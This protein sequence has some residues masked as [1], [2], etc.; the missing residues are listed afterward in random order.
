M[1]STE[2][3]KADI[4]ENFF[5]EDKTAARKWAAVCYG[6]EESRTPVRRLK[7]TAF[8]ERSGGFDIPFSVRPVAG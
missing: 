4:R 1:K 6:G 8:S 5:K 2:T 3:E 7:L